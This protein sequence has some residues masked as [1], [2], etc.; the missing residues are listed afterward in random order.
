MSQHDHTADEERKIREAAL[1]ETIA[2]TFPASDPPSTIPNPDEHDM[3][4]APETERKSKVE[5]Q[6]S[7]CLKCY[8]CRRRLKF[9]LRRKGRS[10]I[11]AS[12]RHSRC[13]TVAALDVVGLGEQLDTFGWARI[14]NL[15]TAAECGEIASLYP[16]DRQFRSHIMMARHGFGRGEYK[17]FAYPLP[18]TIATLRTTLYPPLA[19]I[20]NRWNTSMGV[21][22]RFP[23]DS[24][25]LRRPLPRCRP[26][27]SDATASSIRR[28][29]LQRAAPG[30][31][32]RASLSATAD[33]SAV[34]AGARLRGRRVRARRAATANAIA[35]RSGSARARRRSRVRSA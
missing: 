12:V 26:D 34:S 6:K 7:K 35:R 22:A 1:D 23:C 8:D 32:R 16:D 31:L 11:C 21:A 18:Q 15:I 5:S 2:E 3:P 25:G 14:P 28:R 20:A 19:E 24:C 10:V 27:P 13:M 4:G 9:G 17:Y 33:D 30:R 29:R